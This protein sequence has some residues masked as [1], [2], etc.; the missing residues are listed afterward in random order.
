MEEFKDVEFISE[1]YDYEK[2]KQQKSSIFTKKGL[3]FVEACHIFV[4]SIPNELS[5]YESLSLL[6]KEIEE[7]G[8]F[9]NKTIEKLLN[10]AFSGIPNI[11]A[12]EEIQENVKKLLD[13][14]PVSLSPKQKEALINAFSSEISYIQGPPGT[15]KS[16]T[17]LA[18]VLMSVLMGKKVLV[19]S[20]KVPAVDVINEKIT[21]ILKHSKISLPAI[22]YHKDIKGKLKESVKDLLQISSFSLQ[23]LIRDTKKEIDHIDRDL[24]EKFEKLRRDEEKLLDD[25]DREN[26]IYKLTEKLKNLIKNFENKYFKIN[27][28][29]KQI[30]DKKL[31][32]LRAYLEK[33]KY[34][35]NEKVDNILTLKFR[36]KVLKLINIDLPGLLTDGTLKL[37]K[38]YTLHRM[39][40][41]LLEI[42]NIVNQ[43]KEEEKKLLTNREYIKKDIEIYKKE[44]KSLAE[45]YIRFKNLYNILSKLSQ[46][47]YKDEINKFSKLL[48][49]VSSSKIVEVQKNIDWDK[50]LDVFPIWISEIR[51]LNEILPMKANIFDLVV[52]DEASQVNLAEIIPVFYRGKRI[53]IVGDHKQLSLV[54]TGLNFRL[55]NNL[56]RLTFEKYKPDNLSYET[57]RKK[58]LTVTTSSILDFIRSEENGFFIKEIM[59]DEH[60]R[61]LPML[62]K[63]NNEQFYE[64]KLKIMTETP[65]NI[66]INPVFPIKVEGERIDK[67]IEEEANEVLN[68]ILSITQSRK[69]KD[70]YLPEVIPDKFSIGVIS[71]IR[72]Q[73]ELIKDIFYEKLTEEI[74]KNYDIIVGTPEELQGHERDVI[75]ISFAIDKNS[76]GSRSHYEKPERFNVATSR[77]KFFTFLVY[78]GI[79][80]NFML[81]IKYFNSFGFTPHITDEILTEKTSIEFNIGWKFKPDAFESELEKVV[82]DYLLKYIDERK[83]Y[84][85]KIFN[86]VKAC[87][88]KRLDFVLYNPK[89]KKFVA[90]EVDGI[91]H[92]ELD[93]RTYSQAHKER[94]EV[95][96]RAGWHIINTPYY[97]W[98]RGGW[99]DEEF[100]KVEVKRLYKE[101]DNYLL[102]I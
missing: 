3:T 43:I 61:S 21:P 1:P 51:Y 18:I 38:D 52:V 26:R 72:N 91:H 42:I 28:I 100:L 64:N 39:T 25:V 17:I 48:R 7:R 22:Y 56:D 41:D 74:T 47:N 9:E 94:I 85:M 68:I 54:S 10:G 65:E 11:R 84:D 50:I 82:C 92:F 99:L 12:E 93:G 90:V 27:R 57:A 87:G 62:A 77:A 34:I 49:Y 89:N 63:F 6:I 30:H 88:Q 4:E 80:K 32:L 45:K 67:T 5:A 20:Q 36:L 76:V 2:E 75:I 15:G 95:L 73:V 98:Y 37:L 58:K 83:K 101:L 35:E 86:Q 78:S 40:E 71:F 24:K 81:T 33:L 66:S 23:N 59:L 8:T 53:C 102:G 55:S 44:I 16:H 79:P 97:R 29:T 19:V 46:N 31:K 13:L 96:K 14:I 69:Y 60:F 70:V